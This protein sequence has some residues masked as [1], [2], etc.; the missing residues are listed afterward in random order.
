MWRD[1]RMAWLPR[2]RRG[3]LA[4]VFFLGFWGLAGL[5]GVAI[6]LGRSAPGSATGGFS[7]RTPAP[8]LVGINDCGLPQDHSIPSVLDPETGG[9]APCSFPEAQDLQLLGFSPWR[10]GDGQSQVMALRK[11]VAGRGGDGD[12]RGDGEFGLTRYT[13]PAGRILDQV[14]L[15]LVPWGQVCWFPDRSDRVLF[16]DGDFTLYCYDFRARPGRGG[17]ATPARLQ[18][19][20]WECESP[21]FGRVQ[22]QDPCWPGAP[23]LGGRLIVSAFVGDSPSGPYPGPD[24]WWLQL[25]PD[26]ATILAAGPLIVSEGVKPA[27]VQEEQRM[28]CVQRARDGKLVLAYLGRPGQHAQQELWVAPITFDD[29]TGAP[30]V[31]SSTR[32]KLAGDCVGVALAFSSDGRTIHVS[33]HDK[34]HPLG[35]WGAMRSYPVPEGL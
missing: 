16:A 13:Y 32:R 28:P 4:P 23:E 21:G 15:D 20:R 1:S 17:T 22:I 33:V 6:L 5:C 26:R 10:D 27:L 7:R 25:D 31:L 29:S 3:V 18:V 9:M 35:T 34:Q 24:L 2:I 12:D 19:V 11:H 30:R 14:P 8:A